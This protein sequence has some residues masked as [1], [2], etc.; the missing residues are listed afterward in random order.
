LQD[1]HDHTLGKKSSRLYAQSKHQ[2]LFTII[3]GAKI[4]LFKGMGE[5]DLCHFPSVAENTELS[6]AR[7]Y[8]LTAR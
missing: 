2:R 4:P 6:F 3:P 7:K 5:C 1:L 8:F